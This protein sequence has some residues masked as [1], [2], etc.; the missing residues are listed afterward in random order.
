[1]DLITIAIL[2]IELQHTPDQDIITVLMNPIINSSFSL[3]RILW[4]LIHIRLLQP[5][6]NVMKAMFHHQTLTGLPKQYPKKLKQSPCTIC[7]T[8]NMTASPKVSTVDT[9]NLQPGEHIHMDFSFCNVTSIRGF[10]SMIT[11]VC[12]NIIMIWLFPTS[13]KQTHVPIICCVLTTLKN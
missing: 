11:V 4:E 8:S 12:E 13:S 10:T 3:H 7:Y 9:N 5:S 1:M 6:H 2:K